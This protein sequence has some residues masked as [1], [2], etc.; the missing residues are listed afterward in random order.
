MMELQD[1]LGVEV[2]GSPAAARR[3]VLGRP[4]AECPIC[5]S[6]VHNGG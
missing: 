3:T 4:G 1:G 2:V 5:R 6:R